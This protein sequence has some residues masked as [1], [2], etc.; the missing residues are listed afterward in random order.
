MALTKAKLAM[1]AG[2][3]P[4]QGA[5][6]PRFKGSQIVAFTAVAGTSTVLTEAEIVRLIASEDCYVRFGD[7]STV[8]AT[9]ADMFLKK[10]QAEYFNL[11]KMRYVSAVRV[12]TSGNLYVTIMD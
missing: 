1:D 10:E 6:H 11:R 3:Q 5:L 8:V 4:I 7:F 2:G 12:I 9:A